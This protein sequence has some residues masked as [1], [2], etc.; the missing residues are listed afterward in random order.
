MLFGIPV[1]IGLGFWMM[2]VILG[3]TGG[4]AAM[5]V[6][7]TIIVFF[8][9]M[10]HEL[11]HALVARAFGARP[12]ITLHALGGL[13][14]M[15][16]Q[17]SR[18]RSVLVSLAGPFAGFV[19]GAMVWLA[20]RKLPLNEGQ[21][22]IVSMVLFVN[23]G[24]GIIN[25]LPVVPF[26][27]GHVLAA[28]L[29]PRRA[30]ATAIISA[31]V[32]AGI[33]IYGLVR[34]HSLWIAFLFGSA[35]ASAIAQARLAWTAKTDRREGLEDQLA[36]AKLALEKGEADDAVVLADDVVRRAKSQALRNG[37]WTALA[38]A[39]VAKGDGRAA[40][41]ALMHVEPRGAV[42]AYLLAAVEDAAG[43]ARRALEILE[44]ARRRGLRSADATKLLIDL[45]AREGRLADAAALAAEDA[46][47]LSLDETRMV[48]KAAMDSD[49]HRAAAELAGKLFE[50]HGKIEDAIDQARALAKAGEAQ[51]AIDVLERVLA[52]NA[53]G[54]SP[55]R[56]EVDLAAL[57][58]DPAFETLR[59]DERFERI[60]R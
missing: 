50:V 37:G 6:A 45:R 32:G 16:K 7:W 8:S 42:D 11:G 39:N 47:I 10:I 1:R 40:R 36:K 51:A 34:V 60:V 23:I 25:L 2:A 13:T 31:T 26:D 5:V 57:H 17:F 21:L 49:E 54:E 20:T 46:K 48:L 19:L 30:F 9:V 56:R 38:W 41:E 27:G 3:M 33:A 4:S 29:G 24:W 12:S 43:D 59:G 14:F 52:P 44:E 28:A 35:A 18:P 22:E 55:Y 53:T 58:E 15:D